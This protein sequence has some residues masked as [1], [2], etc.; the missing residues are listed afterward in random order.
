MMVGC[1]Q[2]GS[3]FPRLQASALLV[4]GHGLSVAV[5]C[6]E[7][8]S[9]TAILD[10]LR[11]YR[12]SPRQVEMLVLTHLHFDHSENVD[13]F[14][15]ALVVVHWRELELL[16]RLLRLSTLH[17]LKEFLRGHY[18]ALPPFY[19][20][21]ILQKF[22]AHREDYARLLAD[23]ARLHPVEKNEVV[24]GGLA[25]VETSGHS[26]GHVA[27]GVPGERPVWI[28]GDA[29]SSRR[30]WLEPRTLDQQLVWNSA[31]QKQ[32]WDIIRQWGGVLVPGHGVPF[33]LQT[34]EPVPFHELE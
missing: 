8:C 13:A 14:E 16:E 4:H 33:A 12:I 17:E 10:R 22:M 32:T 21:R 29:V 28:A 9:R 25:I 30:E 26:V 1:L 18:E 31:A 7:R 24:L 11:G 23:R 15:R 5:D 3:E 20:R 2:Q 6:G 19:L 27:V 34:G